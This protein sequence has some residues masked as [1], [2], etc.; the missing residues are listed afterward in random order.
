[1]LLYYLYYCCYYITRI[2]VAFTPQGAGGRG[3]AELALFNALYIFRCA[4][5]L[6]DGA[7]PAP[8]A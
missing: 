2:I 7:V 4:H 6:H 8:I 1:M 5:E 3:E